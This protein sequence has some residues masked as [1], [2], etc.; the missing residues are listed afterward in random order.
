MPAI[1]LVAILALAHRADA[2][3]AGRGAILPW[4][5]Y[6]AEQA[7][8]NGTVLG[9]DYIGHTPAREASGRR[10]V[11]LAAT[12]EFLEFTAKANAQGLVVRYCIPDSPDGRGADA[13]LSL[14]INGKPRMKLPMT[15]RYSYLYGAYPFNNQPSSGSPRHFWDELRLM[16]GAIRRGDVIRIQKDADDA[17]TQY[18]I[19][20]VDLEAGARAVGAAGE[21]A[22]RY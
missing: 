12:G 22:F 6:E 17:A 3:E 2:A 9:P 19:D 7:N 15:S 1:G 14:Y 21:F 16:P 5:T 4:F 8:T 20:F 13:T 10:C 18:L 11:R